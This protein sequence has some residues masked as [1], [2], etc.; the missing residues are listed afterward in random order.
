MPSP[1]TKAAIARFE[2]R[3]IGACLPPGAGAMPGGRPLF[4]AR[5]EAILGRMECSA[6]DSCRT[7]EV[8]IASAPLLVHRQALPD[9]LRSD[10]GS[11]R[12]Y[13]DT[14]RQVFVRIDGAGGMFDNADAL[15]K[16]LSI[17]E[18]EMGVLSA[19]F[20][21]DIRNARQYVMRNEICVA[22]A[23]DEG[24]FMYVANDAVI[25]DAMQC[26]CVFNLHA[27]PIQGELYESRSHRN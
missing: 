20:A 15:P 9:V 18:D 14:S 5:S 7:Y 26:R 8:N 27:L 4:C 25:I 19:A 24:V 11:F 22:I 13:V 1:R 21:Q 2:T 23:L 17:T 3:L 10:A 6:D 16:V 12:S